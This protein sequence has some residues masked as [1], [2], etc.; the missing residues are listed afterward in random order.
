M[1]ATCILHGCNERTRKAPQTA[2]PA[3]SAASAAQEG[4]FIKLFRP[5]EAKDIPKDVFTLV[6]TDYTVITAGNPEHYNSMVAGWGGWG[7]LFSKPA[8]WCFLR[9]SRYTLELMREEQRYTMSYFDDADR[10]EVMLFGM[11]SGRD[12]DKMKASKL[13]P[14]QTPSGNMTYREAR[15]VIECKLIEVTSVT[16]DDFYTGEGRTFVVDAYSETG[17]YHK[18]VFGEITGVWVH[19]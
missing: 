17:D 7:I 3:A 6:G 1:L 4:E 10:E 2:E 14:V 15:L 11:R 9:S 16:P 18:I 19:E 5:I 12:S 13:S 8:T